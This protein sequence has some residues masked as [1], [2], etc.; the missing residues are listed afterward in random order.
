MCEQ[1]HPASGVNWIENELNA[2]PSIWFKEDK[3]YDP[4]EMFKSKWSPKS[5]DVYKYKVQGFGDKVMEIN[6]RT[7]ITQKSIERENYQNDIKNSSSYKQNDKQEQPKAQ[8]VELVEQEQVDFEKVIAPLRKINCDES[9]KVVR[10]DVINKTI[11]RIIRRFFYSLLE[12]IIPD[13]KHQKRANLLNMLASF[14]EF[15]FPMEENIVEIS[16]VLWALMFRREVLLLKGNSE[17][18]DKVQI[19]LDVQSKYTHKL[20][21]PVME[22]KHFKVIFKYFLKN[23]ITFFENDENVKKSPERYRE[24]FQKIKEIFQSSFYGF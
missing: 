16:E 19:F 20:L 17:L 1:F 18:R 4:F 21:H 9:S 8:L 23:G 12:Q 24:E 3:V 10:R 5:D 6:K 2:G 11:F 15:L 7:C 22:N 14:S 13:Y